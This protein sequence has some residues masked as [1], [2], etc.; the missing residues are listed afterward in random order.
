MNTLNRLYHY[1]QS[2]SDTVDL[3]NIQVLPEGTTLSQ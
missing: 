2:P 1:F 3:I